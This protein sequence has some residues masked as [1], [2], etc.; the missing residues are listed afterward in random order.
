[1]HPGRF[2]FS[3]IIRATVGSEDERPCDSPESPSLKPPW[4]LKGTMGKRSKLVRIKFVA[5]LALGTLPT[6]TAVSA[7]ILTLGEDFYCTSIVADWTLENSNDQNPIHVGWSHGDY[8]DTEIGEWNDASPNDPDDKIANERNRR[9]IR[10]A[11]TF[12][13]ASTGVDDYISEKPVYTKM[14]MSIGDGYTIDF[15]AYNFTGASL[16]T[17]AVM[18]VSGTAFG[19]WER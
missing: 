12:K 9:Q 11:G 7:G 15:W 1:M 14:K 16:T 3:Q 5:Q 6:T 4:R 17:G 18:K 2:I 19:R 13:A 10:Q 8:S